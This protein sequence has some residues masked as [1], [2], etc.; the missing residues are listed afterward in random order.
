MHWTL[1]ELLSLPMEYYDV[2]ID[3]AP[4]WLG[5]RDES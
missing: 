1:D 4:T 2:L 3:I 5:N